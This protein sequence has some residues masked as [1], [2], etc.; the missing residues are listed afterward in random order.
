M[1]P[2]YG[3]MVTEANPMTAERAWSSSLLYY[4]SLR[5]TC[6]TLSNN[7]SSALGTLFTYKQK[8][9]VFGI[10]SLHKL[11]HCTAKSTKT[12][13]KIVFICYFLSFRFSC[14]TK[15]F[16]EMYSISNKIIFHGNKAAPAFVVIAIC[17]TRAC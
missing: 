14:I 12:R 8:Q 13:K 2:F 5:L 16:K 11:P 9:F 6:F 4:Y 17:Y 15:K 3:C 1:S 10:W 7:Q